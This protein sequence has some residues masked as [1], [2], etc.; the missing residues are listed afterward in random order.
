M[1][2][3]KR[4]SDACAIM[5][6]VPGAAIVWNNMASACIISIRVEFISG[7]MNVYICI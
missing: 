7:N 2:I 3:N 4:W 1:R 6:L 5:C